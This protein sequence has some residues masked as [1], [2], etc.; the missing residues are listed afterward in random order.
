MEISK[1]KGCNPG[2]TLIE[3][4]IVI[5]VLGIL[6]AVAVPRYLNIPSD[7]QQAAVSAVAGALGTAS[8]TN[9]GTRKASPSQGIAVTNCQNIGNLLPGAVL[10]AGS[11]PAYNMLA[12]Y[13]I[14][15]LSITANT[16]VTC[17]VTRTS[18]GKTA[19][20]TATGIS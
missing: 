14:K 7:A 12:G 15:S 16:D 20:F 18:G 11:S 4:L 10:V 8:A 3:L 19:T 9:Y 13:T 17:T 6:V 1:N 5:I 2:F